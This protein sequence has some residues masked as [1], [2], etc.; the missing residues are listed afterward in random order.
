MSVAKKKVNEM[1]ELIPVLPNEDL[2]KLADAIEKAIRKDDSEK[3]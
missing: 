3:S 1:C 2:L